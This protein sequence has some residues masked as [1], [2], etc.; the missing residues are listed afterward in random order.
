[1]ENKAHRLAKELPF[2]NPTAEAG[3]F[4]SMQ[5]ALC[6]IL[7]NLLSALASLIFYFTDEETVT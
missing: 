6:F 2:E 1:M 3:K 7:F 5:Y 4:S